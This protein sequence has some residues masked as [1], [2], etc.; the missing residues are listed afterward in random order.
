[1]GPLT[2]LRVLDLTDLRG[3]LCARMLADLGADVVRVE[4][5][6]AAAPDRTATAYR[7]R[8]AN[9]RGVAADLGTDAGVAAL[10]ALA[11]DADVL[12]DN[13]TAP[14]AAISAALAAAPSLVHVALRDFGWD[15]PRAAWRLEPLTALAASGTMFATGF[16]DR[17]PCG[18]P[19]HLAHD[20]ASIYGAVGAIAAVL[21]RLRGNGGQRVEVSVQEAALA[22]T[23]PWSIALRDYLRVNPYLPAKGTR[24][25]EGSYWVLPASDGYV[26]SVI[27][28]TRQW[29]GFVEVLGSPDALTT[30]EWSQPG[31]RLMNADVVRLVAQECLTD[32][33]RHEV[34]ESAKGTGA[35]VGVLHTLLEFVGHEQTRG[36][37]FFVSTDHPGVEGLPFAS[38]PYR[39]SATPGALRRPAPDDG[40]DAASAGATT[41]WEAEGAGV[42]GA[43]FSRR[44][45]G[46]LLAGVR[47]VEFGMAAVVPELCGVLSELGAEVIKIESYAH[48][49]VLRTAS[50]RELNKAFTYNSESRGRESVTIDIT[51]PE[52]RALALE[53]CATAD[54]VAENYRGG[55]L[56]RAGLGYEDV[57]AVNPSVIYASSQGYGRGG[58]FAEMPAYGPLN[59]AFTGIQQLWSH[60]D[61][62]YPCGTSL[63]HPDHIVGKLLGVAVLAALAHRDRTGE[64]QLIDMAQ[65]EAGAFLLGEAYLDAARTGDELAVCGNESPTMAPHGV[66]PAAGDD[67]WLALVVTDDDGWARAAAVLGLDDATTARFA[68]AEM[69]VAAR[70]EVDELI[71]AWS[72]ARDPEAAAT[73]LQAAGVS[74]MPVLGP[75]DHHADAHLAARGFIVELEHPE[76]GV[77]HHVGNPLRFSRLPQRIAASAPC[78][79]A[80]TADV[81][82]RVLGR[83]AATIADLVARGICQ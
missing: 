38:V 28:S 74:A 32:R 36:R 71:A 31:F 72:A 51:T 56:D 66:Y 54:I 6:G 53:L 73:A 21:D 12:V 4:P 23:T 19:G 30:D 29:E 34:F 67:R 49:D 24:N 76:V 70:A 17:A 57:S 46:L 45:E 77:E 15:G 3:A 44:P 27:G 25:A 55:V 7:Y 69:R 59:I 33:T 41:A 63:N 43:T 16:P 14:Q 37:G 22:G 79:G 75:D 50:G 83:D 65:T 5:A 62:P 42:A 64:G 20:C 61:G 11:R 80:H 52:G 9:K 35:T 18:V 78:L 60:R 68:T 8:N 1:M 58:P 2:W 40:A 48:P 47:V 26:R 10:V 81:L 82:G 39:L 13:G